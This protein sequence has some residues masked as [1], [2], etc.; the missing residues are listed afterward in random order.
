LRDQRNELQQILET[1]MR[2][3]G[4]DRF[5]HTK[6]R[7]AGPNRWN[8][9]ELALIIEKIDAIFAPGLAALN[10]LERFAA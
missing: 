8:P 6:R 4:R 1:E 2:A 10:Q 5:K 7:Y 3:S 9:P